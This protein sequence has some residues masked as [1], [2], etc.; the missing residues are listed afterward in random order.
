[1]VGFEI[2]DMILKQSRIRKFVAGVV[3]VVF[4]FKDRGKPI[5]IEE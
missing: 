2:D 5:R 1:M 4:F 3:V